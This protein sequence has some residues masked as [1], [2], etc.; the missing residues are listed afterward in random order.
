MNVSGGGAR[1]S[2][3]KEGRGSGAAMAACIAL[4]SSSWEK[5]RRTCDAGLYCS[6]KSVNMLGRLTVLASMSR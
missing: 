4:S 3:R 1:L 2:G 6:A 5:S